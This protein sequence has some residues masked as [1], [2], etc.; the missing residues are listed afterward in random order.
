MFKSIVITLLLCFLLAGTVKSQNSTLIKRGSTIDFEDYPNAVYIEL[1]GNGLPYSINYERRFFGYGNVK[2][3]GRGVLGVVAYSKLW[4]GT[5]PL[6]CSVGFGKKNNFETG[7][8]CTFVFNS[9]DG[10]ELP[11]I[12]LRIGYRLEIDEF[13]FRVGLIPFFEN[14]SFFPML[15]ISFGKR[16]DD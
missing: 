10:F 6:E 13:L 16:F 14:G 1:L 2:L 7:I 9:F 12:P 11:R 4:G 5:I 15:G 3:Y 8:G